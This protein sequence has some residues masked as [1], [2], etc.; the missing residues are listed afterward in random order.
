MGVGGERAA[1]AAPGGWRTACFIAAGLSFVA[2]LASALAGKYQVAETVARCKACQL[3]FANLKLDFADRKP[4]RAV[5]HFK[6]LR[7]A[8]NDVLAGAI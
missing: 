4:A 3:E 8:Y 6:K 5:A 1:A 7:K 2:A